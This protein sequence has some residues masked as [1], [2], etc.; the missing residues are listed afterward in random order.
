MLV[1]HEVHLNLFGSF[2]TKKVGRQVQMLHSERV[3]HLEIESDRPLGVDAVRSDVQFIEDHVWAVG[4][5]V[6]K[7]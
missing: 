5:V 2:I 1:F 4:V 6:G 7:P 3:T